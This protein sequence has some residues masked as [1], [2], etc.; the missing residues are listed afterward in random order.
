[1]CRSAE[2][3]GN[4]VNEQP[5]NL[6][7]YGDAWA[8]TGSVVPSGSIEESAIARA[9]AKLDDVRTGRSGDTA[10]GPDMRSVAITGVLASLISFPLLVGFYFLI[11]RSD[12][13]V[14]AL[15]MFGIALLLLSIPVIGFVTSRPDSHVRC[16]KQF[17]RMLAHGRHDRARRLVIKSDLDGWPR[18]QPMITN[19]GRPTNAPRPFQNVQAFRDFWNELLR[20]HSSPYCIARVSRVLVTPI[21][22][23]LALVDYKLKLIMNSSM[24]GLMFLVIGIF[25]LLLDIATRKVVKVDKRKLLVKVGDEW[26]IFSAEWQGYEEFDTSWLPDHARR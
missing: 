20:S 15:I 26:R 16:L 21:A 12:S 3:V 10:A 23:D 11:Q 8:K 14:G 17:Y 6:R 24:W 25:A 13:R 9:V 2:R 7:P 18:Y 19:L 4:F 22:P 1:M 5:I